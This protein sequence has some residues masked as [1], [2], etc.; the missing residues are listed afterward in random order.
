MRLELISCEV[1]FREMCDSVARS[2]H[3]INLRFLSKGLHDLGG[4][5]MRRQLQ[6]HIDDSPDCDAILLG[7]ALCGNGLHGLERSEEHIVMPRAHDC[8][9]L[10]MGSR[11]AYAEYFES[12]PGTY[13]RST[14]WLER[15]KALQQLASGAQ[16]ASESL[17]ALIERYGEENGRYLYEEFTRYRQHYQQ[18]TYIETGLEPNQSFEEQARA[19]AGERG[20]R[21][22]KTTGSLRLFQHLVNGD[23]PEKDFLIVPPGSRAMASYDHQVIR[24]ERGAP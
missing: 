7:Y 24:C 12:N 23:W 14:G 21:F 19:E 6:Q 1:L 5:G 4:A 11:E 22:S 3:Q 10:L 13:F 9:A 20:W 16:M 8:I 15:G 17:P 2:P 18:L